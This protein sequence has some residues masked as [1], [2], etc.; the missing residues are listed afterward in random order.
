MD[1]AFHP[2]HRIVEDMIPAGVDFTDHE[3]GVHSYM[4]RLSIE[5]PVELDVTRRDGRALEIGST[6][7]LYYAATSSLPSFHQIRFTVELSDESHGR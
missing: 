2:M 6:P 4:T 3:A 7:P 1:E 5:S